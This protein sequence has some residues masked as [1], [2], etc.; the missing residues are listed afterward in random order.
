MKRRGWDAVLQN[1]DSGRCFFAERMPRRMSSMLCAGW[2]NP[3]QKATNMLSIFLGKHFSVVRTWSRTSGEQR[4]SCVALQ[5]RETDMHHTRSERRSST[6]S[7]FYRT[8]PRQSVCLPIPPTRNSQ[9]HNIRWES[10]YTMAR[11]FSKTLPAR[12][13]IWREPP[14]KRIPTPHI[15]PERFASPKPR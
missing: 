9:Q 10:C 1:I 2:R 13:I 15:S 12:L 4:I 3:Y 7:C 14:D 5:I 11:S 8:F 6:A